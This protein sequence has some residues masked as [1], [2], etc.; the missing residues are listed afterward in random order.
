M[1][2]EMEAL[3]CSTSS[4]FVP[5]GLGGSFL[6]R[7]RDSV[8]RE[9]ARRSSRTSK[10]LARLRAFL[11]FLVK[12]LASCL[13]PTHIAFLCRNP[14]QLARDAAVQAGS[15]AGCP[16]K[17]GSWAQSIGARR[18][19]VGQ[20][21]CDRPSTIHSIKRKTITKTGQHNTLWTPRRL[22][23]GQEDRHISRLG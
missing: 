8:A 1:G 22:F 19:L 15:Q 12:T 16:L 7:T 10:N 18:T 6:R 5:S 17:L 23:L 13:F 14:G 3:G 9:S 20:P 21:F 4:F 2:D 11:V